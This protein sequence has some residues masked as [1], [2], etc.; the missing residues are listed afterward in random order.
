MIAILKHG[1]TQDQK[2][3]L[4]QW[5]KHM[6]LDVHLSEGKEVTILGLI[7]DTSRVD[8]EL[9]SSL[10]IVDAVKRVSEPFKQA[11]RTFH[12]KDT[13]VE[14]GNV[15]IGGGYFAMIAGPCSVESEEQIIE[16]A[17]AVKA[18]GANILRGGAFKP[19]T[20]PY[21]FQG[22]KNEGLRLLLEA[23]KVTGLPII[24]EI[25]NIRSLD[26]FNDV[27]IIQIGARNMQNFD[28]LQELGKTKKPI[29]LK[30]G[31]ANTLQEL[32]MS[33]EYIMSEGNENIILCERGIRS[34]ET[35]TRNTLDLSAVPV[36]HE[37]THL[38]V[39]VD[40]SH[41]TGKA[42]LVAPMA[43]AAAACGADG[44]MIEV[45]NNPA[46]ALCDGSQSLTPEQFD[47]VC[48]NVRAIREAMSL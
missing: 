41:A 43:N 3:H 10:E 42:R 47:Q 8:M 32:L 7:G 48:R 30:R 5:L 20:S 2:A 44:L 35:Y 18:S 27:D 15:K 38:P 31:L 26:L 4:I 29:L 14:I 12:P 19:R 9:L 22:L 46:C 33:A 24:T 6:G 23:K 1:T 37:L 16:V 21:A 34:F 36:L 28:L 17:N 25:M 39:V 45:H 13:I 40:P 11:N